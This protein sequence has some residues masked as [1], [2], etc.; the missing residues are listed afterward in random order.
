MNVTLYQ[1]LGELPH[2]N[3]DLDGERLPEKVREFRANLASADGV[4]ISSPE[5]AHGIPGSLKNALD[6]LVADIEFAGKPIVL[7]NSSAGDAE[8]VMAQLIEVLKTMSG[9]VLFC[10]SLRGA[11]VRKALED[12]RNIFDS[13]V[14]E[15]LRAGLNVFVGK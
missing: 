4:L 2:F 12:Q 13:E 1:S 15:I 10:A 11:V 7:I 5:Y 9:E 8:H 6:W 3:P 14:A